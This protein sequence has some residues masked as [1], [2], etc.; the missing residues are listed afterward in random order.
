MSYQ[1]TCPRLCVGGSV[2]S[3]QG[4]DG[5]SPEA[6]RPSPVSGLGA[7][8]PNRRVSDASKARGTLHPK[9]DG[10]RALFFNGGA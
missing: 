9:L 4:K 10:P 2:H 6:T 5:T 1:R 8:H 7:P 3:A